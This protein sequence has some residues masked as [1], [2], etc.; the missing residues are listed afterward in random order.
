MGTLRCAH[1]SLLEVGEEPVIPDGAGPVHAE[2]KVI[3][4]A[5]AV[6]PGGTGGPHP[7]AGSPGEKNFGNV[8]L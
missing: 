3:G 1:R 6:C 2:A 8:L 7:A 4:I 5:A